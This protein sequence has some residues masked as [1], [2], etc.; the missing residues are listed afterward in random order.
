MRMESE[1][2]IVSSDSV[3]QRSQRTLF[4]YR[5]SLLSQVMCRAR[6]CVLCDHTCAQSPGMI[7][8][9]LALAARCS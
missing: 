3:C 7:V 2:S 5:F 1:S 9:T 8:V 4:N 6:A